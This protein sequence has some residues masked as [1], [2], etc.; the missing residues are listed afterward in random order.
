[1]FSHGTPQYIPDCP[2]AAVPFTA[3]NGKFS[4]PGYPQDVPPGLD[5]ANNQACTWK[6]TVTAGKRVKL[7]FTS[8]SFGQCSTLCSPSEEKTQC[9]HLDIYDGDSKNSSKLRR[10]CPGSAMEVT[11]SGG[12][13]VF[14]EFE[15]GFSNDRGTGFEVQY[16][17]T[18][19]D[20]SPKTSNYHFYLIF[21]LFLALQIRPRLCIHH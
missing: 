20:P 21:I 17:E 15:S 11:V 2:K 13:Q 19:D 8:L 5:A 14:V 12:N 16:S 6:I 1:M 4:S 3:S 10:F 18:L 9:T 7:N